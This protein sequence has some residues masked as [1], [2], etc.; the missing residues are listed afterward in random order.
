MPESSRIDSS[1]F[2]YNG[3][4]SDAMGLRIESRNIYGAPKFDKEFITIPGR[5]GE[6]ISS[7]R[8]FPNVQIAYTVFVP[9]ASKQ[10][11]MTKM[12]A[13]K[14]WLYT[15]P[16]RYH[17]LRDTVDTEAFRKAV[18]NTQLDVTQE[19]HRIG[20]FTV[21]F[22][23]LPFRYLNSG[24]QTR[25]F[26]AA[27]PFMNP[28]PFMAKPL[29]CVHMNGR[30]GTLKFTHGLIETDWEIANVSGA[31]FI[32]SEEMLIYADDT[33]LTEHVTGDGFPV[34]EPGATTVSF[35]GAITSV[36]VTPRWV[37]L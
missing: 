35:S 2:E 36:D 15:E 27:M 21:S 18:I 5:D 28:T 30:T 12:T 33:L 14:A 6:L 34:F 37:T 29:I 9:A 13:I 16:D 19:V 10:E 22:S 1:F 7:N 11:L 24:T 4:R 31:I 25:T 32:D 8:R 20:R 26:S 17:E 23:C 3:I